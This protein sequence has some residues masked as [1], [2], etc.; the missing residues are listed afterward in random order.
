MRERNVK[1]AKSDCVT[2]PVS[3][4]SIAPDGFQDKVRFPIQG[5]HTYPPILNMPVPPMPPFLTCSHHMFS[6]SGP[7]QHIPDM[8][9]LGCGYVFPLDYSYLS[10]ASDSNVRCLPFLSR[11]CPHQSWAIGILLRCSQDPCL[12]FLDSPHQG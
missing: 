12:S 2:Y 1:H 3:C 10:F 4:P 8:A 9:H 6:P 5:E 7:T 11:L